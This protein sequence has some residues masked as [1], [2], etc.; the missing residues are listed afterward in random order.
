LVRRVR[1]DFQIRVHKVRDS[2]LNTVTDW[3]SY[4][5]ENQNQTDSSRPE[6]Q[7]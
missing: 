4:P 5:L 1:E 6:H 7:S 3:L 2:L